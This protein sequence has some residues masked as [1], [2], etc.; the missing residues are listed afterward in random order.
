[1]NNQGRW[2]L[3]I[4]AV[5]VWLVYVLSGVLLPFVAGM[6]AAYFLDPVADSL[7]LFGLSRTLSTLLITLT[8]FVFLGVSGA[9]LLPMIEAQVIDFVAHIPDYRHSL[10]L[11][12]GPVVDQFMGYLSP[13]D[14]ER[15]QGAVSEHAGAVAGWALS[16][17]GSVVRG[18]LA[19]MDILSL[20]FIMPIVTFYLLRDW[21]VLVAKVDAWL[22]RDQ[23]SII[24]GRMIEIDQTLS[25][26]VRGQAL[27]CMVLGA[28]YGLALSV[29][30]VELGLVI[31]LLSGLLSFVPY[32]GMLSGLVVSVGLAFAQTG[33]WTLP[34][35]VA[36]IF[37]VGHLTESNALTPRLVGDRIGLHPLW[38]MFRAYDRV[39]R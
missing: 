15:L 38:V 26:F 27:V 14:V 30:G 23:A 20:L 16:V 7:E 6:V 11:K 2:W 18:G 25:A 34:A 3:V 22:P 32:L 12:F 19:V 5:A 31:G 24:R 33:D 17:I 37:A 29:A 36:A 21:D 8:F 35:M 10:Q 4:I 9:I 1:M 39:V 28:Y 13:Q